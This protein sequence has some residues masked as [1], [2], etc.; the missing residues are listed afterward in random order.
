[1]L[2]TKC[3]N[4]P[5]ENWTQADYYALASFFN[6]VATKPDPLATPGG[7]GRILL[8]NRGAPFAINPR[9]GAGQPP[10]FLGGAQPELSADADRR[11]TYADWLVAPENPFFA[12]SL[13][14]RF[15]GAFFHRGII[16]P[17]DDLRNTNPPA[18]GPL[19]EAL[20][21]D[22]VQH[23]FDVRHLMRRI[24]GSRAYQRSS[25]AN[26]TNQHDE[27]NFSRYVPRR[28]RAEV[29][30]DCLVQATGVPE[31]FA[32]APAG[33]SA[34]QLPDANVTSEFLSLFGK[35][36]R[37]EACE[38]ERNDGSN[39]LQALHFINGTSILDRVA[40][41]AGR[42]EQLLAQH[43][44]DLDLTLFLY[45]WALA[46]P[47]TQGEQAL[48]AAHFQEYG[49]PQRKEAAQDLMW[50]LLNSKDFLFNR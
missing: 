6:Q 9:T 3:H 29:L 13:V 48:A 46:R 19:L 17:V 21:S 50:A 38:C 8:V 44:A 43:S 12:R 36:A 33:F 22:F 10:R 1:M 39:M 15:W 26:E 25:Q 31:P 18:N 41:P 14:N 42:L 37:M 40:Q 45:L 32:E 4:H 2:C 11:R 30:L 47:A 23:G 28:L 27:L 35:P 34:S 20:T 7:K 24:V 49:P 16:E 5:A